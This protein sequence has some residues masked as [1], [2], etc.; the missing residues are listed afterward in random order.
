VLRTAKPLPNST[1]TL[2]SSLLQSSIN[3]FFVTVHPALYEDFIP[4]VHVAHD[5]E[6]LVRSTNTL[7]NLTK[8]I[9]AFINNGCL[10]YA[11]FNE[12][13]VR[14]L[15]L[16]RIFILY[17]FQKLAEENIKERK[18][19]FIT[20]ANVDIDEYKERILG[21]VIKKLAFPFILGNFWLKYNNVIYKMRKRQ[22][23]IGLKKHGVAP[24]GTT[25]AY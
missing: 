16:S 11:A 23:R 25:T 3:L 2:G 13:M 17:R 19:S 14:I 12:F 1:W 5:L 7:I 9:K 22:F 10:C 8:F 4:Y 18:I 21:Y 6:S 24:I 20:Y 15:K